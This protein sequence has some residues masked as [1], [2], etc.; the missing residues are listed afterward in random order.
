MRV[1]EEG[2]ADSASRLGEA[3]TVEEPAVA[4]TDPAGSAAG[5]MGQFRPS[6]PAGAPLA[7][8]HVF[9]SLFGEQSTHSTFRRFR[10]FRLLGKG[11]MGVV[12]EAYDPD[13]ARG[14]AL[15]VVKVS[16]RDRNAALA[17]AKALARLS[18]PNV[19]PIYDVGIE[20]DRVFL[21]MELVRGDTLRKWVEGRGAGDILAVYQQAGTALAAAHAA[22]LVHRDFKPDNAIVGNDGRVRVVDFGLACEAEDPTVAAGEMEDPAVITGERR[23]I[24]GTPFYMAP[25]IKAGAAV[26]PAADQYSFCVALADAL[27]RATTPVPRRIVALVDRGRAAEPADRFASMTE[28]LHALAHDPAKAWRRGSAAAALLVVVG[29]GAYVTSELRHRSDA[30]DPCT[31]GEAKID[32]V[33]SSEARAAALGRVASLGA[34]GA[35][36]RPLLERGLDAHRRRWIDAFHAACIDQRQGTESSAQIDR[37]NVCL[38]RGSDGFAAVRDLVAHIEPDKLEQLPRAVQA[39]DDPMQCTDRNTLT[40]DIEP[41]PAP[42]AKV[43][44]GLRSEI[45]RTRIEV[46]AGRYEEALRDARQVTYDARGASYTPVVAEALLVQGHALMMLARRQAVPVLDEAVKLAFS[47]RDMALG[48]EAWARRAWAQGTTTDPDV[49]LAGFETIEA[50][51][52]GAPS[53][54][55]ARALLYNNVASVELAGG[56]RDRAQRHFA[57]AL[58]QSSDVTDDRAPQLLAIRA[59]IG[60]FSDDRDL[61]DKLLVGVARERAARLGPSHPDTLLTQ[62]ER[63]VGT[64]EDLRR[65]QE[66]LIPTCR[67]YEQFA[68]RG[69]NTAKCWAEAAF[70]AWELGD[71]DEAINAMSRAARADATSRE[72]AAYLTLLRGDERAAARLF[73]AALA[74]A[75]PRPDELWWDVLTRAYLHLGLGRSRHAARDLAGARPALE[76]CIA[77]LESILSQHPALDYQ[78]RLGR[79]YIELAFVLSEIG[80][81]VAAR[82][83]ITAAA[84]VRLRRVGG[85]PDELARLVATV[86]D[87]GTPGSFPRGSAVLPEPARLPAR[88]D[89]PGD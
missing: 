14:I 34:Y 17:E 5:P 51:A 69:R 30:P 15:K 37:R 58:A 53:G 2:T 76:Q 27:S 47:S 16:A 35:S 73:E 42:L 68:T 32:G 33:W 26:T 87:S 20:G 40:S 66:V 31:T 54:A 41:P 18:H 70:V 21:V 36:L 29:V 8:A 72:T 3:S 79:A 9:G 23:R 62:L 22:G 61:G 64:I 82:A 25:E 11:A 74:D 7:K 12:H 57:Q 44:A 84:I 19:V 67:G 89:S 56:H 13:L 83:P 10:V 52:R 38:A 78:R 77:E 1:I 50:V 55:F 60:L 81:S 88:S 85:S 45:A 71:R 49:A 4:P 65:A 63:A 24:A 43:V 59:N 46:G 6:E 80:A 48:V 39:L 86:P 75:A 28:L